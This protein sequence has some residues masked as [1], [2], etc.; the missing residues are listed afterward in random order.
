MCIECVIHLIQPYPW[1]KNCIWI[2]FYNNYKLYHSL[3]CYL[4]L[5]ML[6]RLY[7][8][9]RLIKKCST[10]NTERAKRMLSYYWITNE[11]NFI[12]KSKIRNNDAMFFIVV[13]TGFLFIGGFIINVLECFVENHKCHLSYIDS[14][15]DLALMIL[16]SI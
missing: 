4:F 15:W 7:T 10:F 2:S 14:V 8:V 5:V 6:I 1:L 11:Y 16:T 9:G 12:F 3:N 13:L